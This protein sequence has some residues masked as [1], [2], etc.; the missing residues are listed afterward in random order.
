MASNH[1]LRSGECINT[2]AH[3]YKVPWE[4]IWNHP[5]NAELKQKR[6]DPNVLKAGD[7]IFIPDKEQKTVSVATGKAHKFVVKGSKTHLRLRIVIDE[8]PPPEPPPAPPPPSADRR[9][10]SGED[11]DPPKGKRE[12]KPR[13]GIAYVLELGDRVIKGTTDGDGYVNCEI[14]ANAQ[15]GKLVIQPGTPHETEIE[16]NL[17]HLD[18][19][20]EV[21]GVKQRLRNLCFDCGD[22]NDEETPD[23]AAA[24][25]AFQTKHALTATGEVD[26]ETRAELLKAHGN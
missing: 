16:L 8:G 26:D 23:F 15:K 22:D 24:V 11:P 12:D 4:K 21:S 2:L 18:P 14:P 10:V 7:T 17:G 1:E 3:D 6:K 9:N 25:R 20:D 13:P 19:I 5:N